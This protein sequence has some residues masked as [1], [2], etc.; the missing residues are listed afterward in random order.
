M[1]TVLA[2][3][4]GFLNFGWALVD[5]RTSELLQSG[6]EVMRDATDDDVT[7]ADKI[8][9]FVLEF[10]PAP[11]MVVIENQGQSMILRAIELGTIVAFRYAGVPC[12]VIYAQTIKSHFN[13]GCHGNAENKKRAVK[14]IAELGYGKVVSHVADSILMALYVVDAMNEI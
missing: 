9:R 4:P 10:E 6:V 12:K 13:L 5:T 3:D 1:S 11:T 2:I 7:T 8:V 14:K